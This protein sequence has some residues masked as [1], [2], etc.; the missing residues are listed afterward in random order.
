MAL[1][2]GSAGPCPDIDGS[3]AALDGG[4]MIATLG[5]RLTTPAILSAMRPC[6]SPPV[7]GEKLRPGKITLTCAPGD[8][9][10]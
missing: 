8:S 6:S 3:D 4:M 5:T 2:Y 9:A 10:S 1:I 7:C